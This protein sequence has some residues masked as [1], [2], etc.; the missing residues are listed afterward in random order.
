MMESLVL[1]PLVPR[2]G[3]VYRELRQSPTF[4]P[5]ATHPVVMLVRQK[6]SKI[7]VAANALMRPKQAS[8]V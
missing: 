7:T 1:G 6:L 8:F 2:F 5:S 3:G 4:H